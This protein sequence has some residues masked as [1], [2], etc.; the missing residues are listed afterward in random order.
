MQ[1]FQCFHASN[2]MLPPEILPS[3][4]FHLHDSWQ[5]ASLSCCVQSKCY[6]AGIDT[7]ENCILNHSRHQ[8][9]SWK[10]WLLTFDTKLW[11]CNWQNLSVIQ[12][13]GLDCDPGRGLDRSLPFLQGHHTQT[14]RIHTF[15]IRMYTYIR[16]YIHTDVFLPNPPTPFLR[17]NADLWSCRSTRNHQESFVIG[18][19]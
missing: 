6:V 3:S 17:R 1:C 11:A 18:P 8:M 9:F 5:Y 15:Y 12:D 14:S 16:A 19:R 7:A 10:K 13:E 4:L 2:A